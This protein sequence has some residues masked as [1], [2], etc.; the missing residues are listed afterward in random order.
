MLLSTLGAF[1]HRILGTFGLHGSVTVCERV[2]LF[3]VNEV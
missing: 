1:A 3:A 2:T